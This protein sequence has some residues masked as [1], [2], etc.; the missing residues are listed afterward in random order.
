ML[1]SNKLCT[2][3]SLVVGDGNMVMLIIT[4]RLSVETPAATQFTSTH[5][6]QERERKPERQAGVVGSEGTEGYRVQKYRKVSGLQRCL[7]IL[8][9]LG[10][11]L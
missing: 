4:D 7:T 2:S 1:L 8:H 5:A 11:V 3:T 9:Q 6:S 10:F